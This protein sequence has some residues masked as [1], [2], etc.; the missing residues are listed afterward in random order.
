LGQA[1]TLIG[2][3]EIKLAADLLYPT[4]FTRVLSAQLGEA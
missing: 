4:A 1:F 2:N 3:Y